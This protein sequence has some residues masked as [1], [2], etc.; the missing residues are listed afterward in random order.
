MKA[1]ELIKQLQEVVNETG[2]DFD[3]NICDHAD[4]NCIWDIKYIRCY[5]KD[6]YL[7]I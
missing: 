2:I 7:F 1:T 3:V 4:N 5:N 6:L